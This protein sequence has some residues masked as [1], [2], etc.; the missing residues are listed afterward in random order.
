VLIDG[1]DIKQLD[2]AELRKNISYVAQDTLLFNGSVRENIIYRAPR[3]SDE[4]IIHVATMSGVMDFVQRNPKGFDLPVGEKGALLSGGQVQSIAIARAILLNCP[5]VL[6]DEPTNQMDNNS[7][8]RFIKNMKPYLEDKTL[9]LVTHKTSLLELVDRIIVVDEGSIVMDGPKAE[10][11]EK[12]KT[13][14]IG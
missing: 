9:I 10:V 14:K 2:P 1:I 3:A 12:L 5:M 11:F 13:S 8:Q 4:E 6:L 7:E